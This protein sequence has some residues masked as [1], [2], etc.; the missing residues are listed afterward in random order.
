MEIGNFLVA[1]VS[2]LAAAAATVVT[3]VLANRGA[4]K[5]RAD[6]NKRT[7]DAL[8]DLELRLAALAGEFK[9]LDVA[10][11][12]MQGELAREFNEITTAQSDEFRLLRDIQASMAAYGEKL[13]ANTATLLALQGQLQRDHDRRM[14]NA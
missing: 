12:H 14:H 7:A 9:T 11:N 6:A 1:L 10:H 4:R 2:M 3:I 13:A 8:H 5:E